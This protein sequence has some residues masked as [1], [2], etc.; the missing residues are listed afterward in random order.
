MSFVGDSDAAP[1]AEEKRGNTAAAAAATS[2]AAS[3]EPIEDIGEQM[4]TI[5]AARR[6]MAMHHRFM[7]ANNCLC[8]GPVQRP[9]PPPSG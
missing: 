1:H 4:N 5:H 6:G 8:L 3:P 7:T 9:S 2:A